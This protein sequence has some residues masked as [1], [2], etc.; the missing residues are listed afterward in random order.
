MNIDFKGKRALIR[1]D[2]NVPLNKENQITDRTRIEKAAPT[3]QHILD[4]GGSCILMSHLGRPQ[5]KKLEDGSIDVEKFT[6]RH[7]VDAL[8]ELFKTSIKF[9]SQ[10]VGE[11]VI[12]MS[13]NLRPGEIML[14]ENT[15]F[16]PEESK[17]D[18]TF[19]ARL[20]K[21]GDVYINDA[22]GTAHRAHASTT[23]VAKYFK[24]ENKS[25]GFL[26]EKEIKNANRVL[27][28]P[29]R[30]SVAILGGAKVSDKIQLIEKLLDFADQILIGG[31]MSYTFIKALGGEV[32][33][34]LCEDEHL[35]LAKE[36][37]EK[38]KD[39]NVDFILPED[40]VA[41]DSFS[42]D[43]SFQ[44]VDTMH[45]PD[46]MMGLDIGPKAIQK[47]DA[48]ID[49][50]Q[51]IIWNGPVGVFEM[52]NFSKGT[53]AIAN[54]V[55]ASTQK[56]AFSLIGGGDSVSAINK[57]GLSDNVSFISTGGGAMLEYL[58]GKKLPAII[59]MNQPGRDE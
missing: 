37:L 39:Q 4:Q 19:A 52:E 28:S 23:T 59:A 10:T 13:K 18:E 2:F 45:I 26:V 46:N 11:D 42:N 43:A 15:R 17:G 47:F 24:L 31:G 20:S 22:F 14:I 57:T 41:A 36:L 25:F 27:K 48:I 21:L 44:I 29:K 32:G 5:K 53:L 7:L 40:T 1:V 35:D 55:A 38:A 50:A 51:T 33:T 49:D 30:P 6:L 9:S 54:S 34:S 56:G 8:S 12:L 58:E 16:Y 3:I